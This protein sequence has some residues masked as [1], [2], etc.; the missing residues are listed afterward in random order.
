M[1][2]SRILFT[3]SLV[4]SIFI[5]DVTGGLGGRE[6]SF[7]DNGQS[8]L[9]S[10][11]RNCISDDVYR[12]HSDCP[13]HHVLASVTSNGLINVMTD[14]MLLSV[15]SLVDLENI[16]IIGHDNPTVNCNNT[17][18]IYFDHCHNCT[19]TGI[20]WEKCGTANGRKP[21]MELYNCTNVVIE[22]CSFQHSVTQSITLSEMSGDMT[23]DHCVFAFNNHFKRH[24]VAIHYLSKINH[25]SKFQFKITQC[26][27]THNGV[28]RKQSIV[29]IGPST[30]KHLEHILLIDSVFLNNKGRAIYISHQN[31]FVSGDI[32]IKG[33]IAHKGG[34]IFIRKYTKLSVHEANMSFISNKAVYGGAFYIVDNSNIIFKANSIVIFNSNQAT[35]E[36][37]ALCIE[38]NSR[39][40][41]KGNSTVT[42]SNNQAR[43]YGGALF[44]W[45]NSRVIFKENS[46]V[47]ISNNQV[48]DAGGALCV[49]QNSYVIFKGNST[50]TI[51][52]NQ[53]KVDG[54]ALCIWKSDVT[55]KENSTVKI[56]NNRVDY[57]DG[58]AIYS[59]ENSDIT[60]DGNS[61]VTIS[62]NQVDDNGG[63]IYLWSSC[64]VTFKGNSTVKFYGNVAT[65]LGGAFYVY[66]NCIIAFE[67]TSTVS[68]SNNQAKV[69]GGAL[70]LNNSEVTFKGNSVVKFYNNKAGADGGVIYSNDNCN[71]VM[72]GN[73]VV[74]FN[75]NVASYDGGAVYSSINSDITFHE[76]STA[77]FTDN[78]ATYFGGALFS[79][80]N[81]N[82]IFGNNCAV[83][84]NHN[85]AS[86]GGA[87]FTMSN[88]VFTGNSTAEFGNNRAMLGGAVHASNLIFKGNTAVKFIN[89]NA[90][91]NGGALYSN[92][93]G[94]MVKQKSTINFIQNSAENGGAVFT[95]ALLISEQSNVTFNKNTAGQDGGAI[96]SNNL[97]NIIFDNSSTVTFMFNIAD[98][99]GGAIYS[100]ISRN[101]KYFNISEIKFSNNAAGIAGN[102]LYIDV[103]KSYDTSCLTNRTV[104]ISDEIL[105]NGTAG[106]II[107]TSPKALKLYH[108][109]KCI[110]NNTSN[111][112][113]EEYYI[114]DIMLGQELTIHACLLDYYDRPAEVTQFRIIS[115][116]HQD[117]FVHGSE[118]VSISCGDEI[119]AISIIGNKAISV[120]LNY[121]IVF[122]SHIAHYFS[123]KTISVNLTIQLLPCHPGF[124]HNSKSQRCECYNSSEVVYCSGSSSAIKR[125]YWIGYVAGVQTVTFCPIGY[126]SFSSCEATNGYHHLSPAGTN[127]CKAHRTGRACGNC[128]EG[129][130]LP[131]YSSECV[132][133]DDCTITWTIVVVILTVVYWVVI[134]MAVFAVMHYQINIGYFYAITY[135]YS[136]V[137]ALLRDTLDGFSNGLYT[138]INIMYCIAELTP[139][140]LGKLCLAKDISGIDQQFIHYIHPVAVALI[141]VIITLL[142]RCSRRISLLLSRIVIR[143]ICFL[144]LLSYTSVTTTSLC[145]LKYLRF[146]HVT[147]VYTY[148]SPDIEYFHGRHL[149]YGMIAIFCTITIVIGLPLL[150]LLEP[151]INRKI[152]FTKIKPLLDQF[153]GCYKDKCRWFAAYYMICRLLIIMITIN[154]GSDDPTAQ[155]LL[156]IVCA[157]I[158]LVHLI[159]KPYNIMML[160][161]FDGLF[162][163]LLVLTTVLLLVDFTQSN[164]VIQVTLLL[165]F[166]PLIIVGV[167]CLLTHKGTIKRHFMKLFKKLDNQD[168]NTNVEMFST[169]FDIIIDDSMRVNATICDM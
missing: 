151:F 136:T 46:N 149:A 43:D 20:T 141:L 134:F 158:V 116:D 86:Q 79:Q 102:L 32:L 37:G 150:L 115:Q 6:K 101:T 48:D 144:L 121:S 146:S 14:V 40:T 89:N 12:N 83:V 44:I 50:V 113:C 55:F 125:G 31:V 60:F 25:H 93:S 122:T 112:E 167:A 63:A 154:F 18:G 153:Q 42:I 104:G 22:N 62:N 36:G 7:G 29:Y 123:K 33:N 99:Y 35:R 145:L 49:A 47:T 13:F 84:F 108:P 103:Q 28:N 30:N 92:Y 139:R 17:G 95:S 137:D 67:E 143:V 159:V 111:T 119:K 74:I 165:L 75:N 96:H 128:E 51:G 168:P 142:A 90:F 152:N 135:Y 118:Y 85:E 45:N 160:N 91:L 58:G 133:T 109:A 38:N 72:K 1:L 27:F 88:I 5:Q 16:T 106:K 15:I 70:Y 127:Q 94:V 100:K 131:Y 73:S 54:G 23:I 41:F 21:A 24:G 164:L 80:H 52:N 34:G 8:V 26:N 169:N 110:S 71:V 140:F 78:R 138:F 126:C 124:Q 10:S 19:I 11:D 148:L 97:N 107:A 98:Y 76:N 56:S 156:I 147:K 9:M 130:T 157:V 132:N 155:Y 59:W 64:N 66:H 162:L 69:N 4:L 53:A 68:I 65:D 3:V 166:L 163:L 161:V 105:Q 82:I 2:V 87:I 61:V 129:Y 81:S 120:P 114:E 77:R 117:Y 39:V 57:Y